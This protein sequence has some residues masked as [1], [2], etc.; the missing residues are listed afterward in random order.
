MSAACHTQDI[1]PRFPQREGRLHPLPAVCNLL[2]VSTARLS[3]FD[4][5]L[6]VLGRAPPKG[7]GWAHQPKWDGYRFLVAKLGQRIRLYSKS[8]AEW[9][10]R[11]PGLAEVLRP[12]KKGC[13]GPA[14]PARDLPGYALTSAGFQM[15]I[16]RVSGITK[17]AMMKHT[18][19]TKI[20]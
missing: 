6:P 9:S 11:L 14:G 20:G 4:P 12:E 7:P 1:A 8:G 2:V 15:L 19:G 5:R 13:A 3:F 10:D 17:I 16:L 18:A